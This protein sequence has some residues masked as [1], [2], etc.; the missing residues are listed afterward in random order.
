MQK[1]GEE[2]L[3]LL[4]RAVRGTVPQTGELKSSLRALTGALC[5]QA[6]GLALKSL[7]EALDLLS[8]S[9]LLSDSACQA[10]VAAIERQLPSAEV[11]EALLGD[12]AA[13]M[14]IAQS[15]AHGT[16]V[17]K[18]RLL[19]DGAVRAGTSNMNAPVRPAWETT[20]SGMAPSKLNTSEAMD[21]RAADVVGAGYCLE[22]QSG[23]EEGTSG[24]GACAA[25]ALGSPT[26]PAEDLASISGH[27]GTAPDRP[28]QIAAEQVRAICMVAS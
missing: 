28:L 16:N 11:S 3:S 2:A 25:P 27:R 12:L 21:V 10:L 26:N 9:R 20:A 1:S 18:L 17:G 4:K 22:R 15:N 24:N 13:A 19:E 8:A 14:V 5:G 7:T 6:D 23:I